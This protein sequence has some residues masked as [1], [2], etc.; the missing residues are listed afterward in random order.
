MYGIT[1][2]AGELLAD[3]YFKR[4]GVDTRG[5]RYPGII[6]HVAPPGG[7][8]TDY[9]V[10]IY[11]KAL[12]DRKY[13]CFLKSGTFLPMIY[14]PDAL[15]ATLMLMEADPDKLKHRNAFNVA[16]MS[17]A[18]EDIAAEIAGH[19]PGFSMD[20]KID[21]TRQAIAQSWPTSINDSEARMQWGWQPR[22]DLASMTLD[23]LI[24]LEKKLNTGNLDAKHT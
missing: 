15:D 11:Y 12:T 6:S 13:T 16:S 22:F 2:V 7:G 14:M 23:M 21:E 19:V 8:T 24:N 3:Y 9:A 10:E 20:Y 1:K 5:I 4:W 18:P 17:F